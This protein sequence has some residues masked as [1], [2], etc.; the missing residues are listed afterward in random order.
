MPEF[1]R[2]SGTVSYDLP[3]RAA[4]PGKKRQTF[5]IYGQNRLLNDGYKGV[6]AGKTGYST[7]A[8][9]T[10]W[11]AAKRHGHTV[12]VTLMG[13][14]EETETAARK[15]MS[16]GLANDPVATPVGVL[17]DPVETHTGGGG[18]SASPAAANAGGGGG[19]AAAG[20]AAQGSSSPSTGLL[21]LGLFL[22]AALVV[23]AVEVFWRRRRRR[24]P[25][26]PAADP[27]PVPAPAGPEPVSAPATAAPTG[28]VVVKQPAPGQP[29]A[30][31]PGPAEHA[32]P[33]PVAPTGNVRVV[34]PPSRPD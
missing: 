20:P 30:E 7:L 27:P 3:G 17:V 10:F 6:I 32:R 16:W 33:A 5:K 22:L 15:L 29:P 4:K 31:D 18:P 21:L 24:S 12:I 13:I 1:T 23:V 19:I 8:G 14:T 2:V 26:A 34:R 11:V 28:S 25:A 9:R